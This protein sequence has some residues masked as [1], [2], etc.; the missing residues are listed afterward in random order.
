M[1]L[2]A[3][4]RWCFSTELTMGRRNFIFHRMLRSGFRGDIHFG[5]DIWIS[6]ASPRWRA[7]LFEL[8]V[9]RASGSVARKLWWQDVHVSQRS[10]TTLL[11][12]KPSFHLT[13]WRCLRFTRPKKGLL[14]S[15]DEK[16]W[17]TGNALTRSPPQNVIRRTFRP[18][19]SSR[20]FAKYRA[21]VNSGDPTWFVASASRNVRFS[22][23]SSP[24][25]APRNA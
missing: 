20:F 19:F 18:Q 17:E 7:F 12:W 10:I 22:V 21:S 15:K 9:Q 3:A 16:A 4:L 24:S 8:V 25:F 5:P 6:S 2:G 11:F 14:T 23:S 1:G 13:N